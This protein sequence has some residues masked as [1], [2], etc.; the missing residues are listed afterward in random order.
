ME[1]LNVMNQEPKRPMFL[2]VLCV[3]SLLSMSVTFLGSIN[4]MMNGPQT[5]EQLLNQ[6][7]ELTKT[8]SQLDQMGSSYFGD[9]VR[10]M[11]VMTENI[12]E[13]FLMVNVV[14]IISLVFGFFGVFKMF[15]GF[16]IGFHFYIVYS[17]ISIGMIYLFVDV[18]YVP[19]MVLYWNLFISG[20]FVLLY[21]RNLSWMK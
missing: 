4:Q 3:L 11:I 15:K 12:N 18:A 7:V 21:S 6:K 20:L 19:S 8:A 17:L 2:K 16:K 14:T 10:K 5:E 9:S 1:E 13:N